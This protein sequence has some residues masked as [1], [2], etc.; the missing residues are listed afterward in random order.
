MSI[1]DLEDECMIEKAVSQGLE[2]VKIECGKDSVTFM[3]AVRSFYAKSTQKSACNILI[4]TLYCMDLSI[5]DY[6][7]AE[8]FER[9]LAKKFFELPVE[10]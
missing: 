1:L 8:L 6:E 5:T 3:D 4:F 9:V 10:A 7:Y 2:E